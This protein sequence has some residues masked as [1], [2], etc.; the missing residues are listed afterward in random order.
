MQVQRNLRYFVIVASLCIFCYQMNSALYQLMSEKSLDSTE[1]IPI[2][3]LKSPP[4]IT[5]CPRQT[6]GRLT[7]YD[8]GLRAKLDELGFFYE[9]KMFLGILFFVYY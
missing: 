7:E 9:E 5:F 2:S 1:Y 3:E 8:E 6:F 4:V